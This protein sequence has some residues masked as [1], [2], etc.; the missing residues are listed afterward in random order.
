MLTYGGTKVT[1]SINLYKLAPVRFYTIYSV[2]FYSFPKHNSFVAPK[3]CVCQYIPWRLLCSQKWQKRHTAHVLIK[4][5]VS[6]RYGLCTHSNFTSTHNKRKDRQYNWYLCIDKGV[7]NME[8]L[9]KKWTPK[10]ATTYVQNC[11]QSLTSIFRPL[12]PN[13]V[14]NGPSISMPMPVLAQGSMYLLTGKSYI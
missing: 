12:K 14:T 13:V 1:P 6:L 8:L 11:C 2:D 4:L 7:A 9:L 10:R 5:T 3:V